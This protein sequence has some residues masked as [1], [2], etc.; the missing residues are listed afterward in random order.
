MSRLDPSVPIIFPVVTS[1]YCRERGSEDRKMT[2]D[3]SD[4]AF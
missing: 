3:R 1:N 2:V 4:I